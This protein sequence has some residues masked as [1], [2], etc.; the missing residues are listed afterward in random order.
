V[1]RILGL[2][3]LAVGLESLRI[4]LFSR[5]P[6]APD[7]LLGIVVLVAL[8]RHSPVGAVAGFLLG[9]L[10]DLLY[11]YPLGVEALPLSL[12]GW[13]VGSSGRSLY[14]EALLTQAVVLLLAGLGKSLLGYWILSRGELAGSWIYLLRVGLPSSLVTALVIPPLFE[15]G[16]KPLA[17]RLEFLPRFLEETWKAYEKRLLSKRR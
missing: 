15:H 2:L 1:S 9:A 3:L 14:R 12:V 8:V 5:F 11:G 7:F 4:A 13:V 16:A 10:R 17:R 6:A